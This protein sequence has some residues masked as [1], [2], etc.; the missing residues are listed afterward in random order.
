V[1][2]DR[3]PI[4][5]AAVIVAGGLASLGVPACEAGVTPATT[6]DK[7]MS[8]FQSNNLAATDALAGTKKPTFG[9]VWTDPFQVRPDIVMPAG[10]AG[11]NLTFDNL[12]NF[13]IYLYR[14]PPPEAIV[15]ITAPS[16]DEAELAFGEMV[17]FDDLDGD[18]TFSVSGPHAEITSGDTYLAGSYQALVYV[19]RPFSNVDMAFPIL[20]APFAGYS[21]IDYACSGLV[22]MSVSQRAMA[23]F[24]AQP[25]QI[26][27]EIRLCR[28]THSP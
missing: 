13:S 11:S 19:A 6:Y 22:S 4:A 10:W 24:V 27:P 25:S 18:G 3:N 5:A 28:R 15:T 9:V 8:T 23:T 20:N 12:G 17:V 7:E 16:R 14:P 26:L 2:L 1:V 21:I